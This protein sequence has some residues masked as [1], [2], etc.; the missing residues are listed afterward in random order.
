MTIAMLTVVLGVFANASA[1]EN[2][3]IWIVQLKGKAVGE[4]RSIPPIEATRTTSKE[5]ASR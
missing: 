1:A 2:G 3:R 5:I 4:T